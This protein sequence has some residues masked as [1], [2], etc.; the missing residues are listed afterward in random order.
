MGI[1]R[2]NLVIQRRY[3]LRILV[4][5]ILCSGLIITP[6]WSQTDTL[7]YAE[8]KQQLRSGNR[9]LYQYGNFKP[10][11]LQ[12]GFVVFLTGDSAVLHTFRQMPVN[13]AVSFALSPESGLF[14]FDW[15]GEAFFHFS[16][17]CIEQYGIYAPDLQHY[18]AVSLFHG[19][20]NGLSYE[21]HQLAKSAIQRNR[22]TNQIWKKRFRH[23]T[24]II[25]ESYEGIWK[26]D[27]KSRKSERKRSH[28][29]L[30]GTTSPR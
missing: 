12:E 14:R 26:E 11:N 23:Y 10:R 27:Q 24:K 9:A 19:W 18:F 30:D 15:G 25:Y 8:A 4:V 6:S 22:K 1:L 7:A 20:M 28:R 3:T 13:E 17:F 5:S 21:Q 2:P 29:H 16:R